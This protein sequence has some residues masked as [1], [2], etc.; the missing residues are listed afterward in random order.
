MHQDT[1]ALDTSLPQ[2][3]F[4]G[5]YPEPQLTLVSES[6]RPKKV[7]G[8][9]ASG[10]Q[11][12]N[13]GEEWEVE[14]LETA[15]LL[16][17]GVDAG[18]GKN[19]HAGVEV[20][21]EG[22]RQE[23]DEEEEDSSDGDI[24]PSRFAE[25]L[26]S[27]GHLLKLLRSRHHNQEQVLSQRLAATRIIKRWRKWLGRRS[28]SQART[29]R[30]RNAFE[31]H[32][33]R[34]SFA[35]LTAYTKLSVELHQ[36]EKKA[37]AH[38]RKFTTVPLLRIWHATAERKRATKRRMAKARVQHQ[39]YMSRVALDRWGASCSEWKRRRAADILAD[40]AWNDR[41]AQYAIFEWEWFVDTEHKAKAILRNNRHFFRR[42]RRSAE[43][44]KEEQVLIRQATEQCVFA[45]CRYGIRALEAEV[46]FGKATR[47]ALSWHKRARQ[48][49]MFRIWTQYWQGR[50]ARQSS[51]AT[52]DICFEATAARG[53]LR[54]LS[55]YRRHQAG[56]R[57]ARAHFESNLL[58]WATLVWCKE[59]REA[60]R[61]SNTTKW[62]MEGLRERCFRALVTY[63]EG[64]ITKAA[65]GVV[66][67]QHW[68]RTSRQRCIRLLCLHT[69]A[70]QQRKRAVVHWTLVVL[71]RSFRQWVDHQ[72]G[73]RCDLMAASFFEGVLQRCFF[74]RWQRY[75]ESRCEKRA[76]KE[77][78]DTH[79]MRVARSQAVR[80]IMGH[81]AD[82][83]DMRRAA[84]EFDK[85]LTARLF[86]SWG[87]GVEESKNEKRASKLF[88]KLVSG[89][90]LS[91]W[92]GR[93][94]THPCAFPNYSLTPSPSISVVSLPIFLPDSS[95]CCHPPVEEGPESAR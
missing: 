11:G 31:T 29:A 79:W 74:D 60:K 95:L 5:T 22:G 27:Q 42:W 90:M 83:K 28:V 34:K 78:A 53:A 13:E 91:G 9:A 26:P 75:Y 15:G 36:M 20:G 87:L 93:A 55:L 67:H 80:V 65:R 86:H 3:G 70:H 82:I 57:R 92:R 58:A 63:V 44:T 89:R 51:F 50:I 18:E 46:A 16:K 23:Q 24:I 56:T 69:E 14:G 54:F 40:R 41:L 32:L 10:T 76:F 48:Q 88:T 45:S 64:R 49:Q 37:A 59:A 61:E 52:A 19:R 12:E 1:S 4:H 73:E 62:Y 38:H 68:V 66:A 35:T 47:E 17:E 77:R 30:A 21:G 81:I 6:R 94:H 25:S 2:P 71:Q 39:S 84:R 7:S 43:R 8:A 33:L 85:L 72:L